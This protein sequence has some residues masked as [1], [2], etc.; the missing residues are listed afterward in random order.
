MTSKQKLSCKTGQF[1]DIIYK[2]QPIK[3]MEQKINQKDGILCTRYVF[4]TCD[5]LNVF[6]HPCAGAVIKEKIDFKED[7]VIVTSQT[8]KEVE[9]KGMD[10]QA[11]ISSVEVILGT[12]IA[13]EEISEQTISYARILRKMLRELHRGDDFILAHCITTKS[14]LVTSDNDLKACCK[15][16]GSKY[17][18]VNEEMNRYVEKQIPGGKIRKKRNLG[19]KIRNRG[20]YYSLVPQ[21]ALWDYWTGAQ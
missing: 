19:G 18:C 9:R 1:L 21:R 13:C 10:F 14:I 17:V 6:S 4:D 5:L 11:V 15:K 20:R 3:I 7:L 16:I 2:N 8:R 12:K